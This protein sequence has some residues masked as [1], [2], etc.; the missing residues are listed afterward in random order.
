MKIENEPCT[1]SYQY[2]ARGFWVTGQKAFFWRKG[3]V[4]LDPQRCYKINEKEK[5]CYNACVL[6]IDH[7]RH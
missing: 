3:N 5:K 6:E 1:Y 7:L 4:A 2:S